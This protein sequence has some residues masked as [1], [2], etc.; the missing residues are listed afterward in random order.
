MPAGAPGYAPRVT[1]TG[2]VAQAGVLDL[3]AAARLHLSSDAAVE[4]LGGTPDQAPDRYR[5]ADPIAALPPPVPVLCVHARD[6]D[7]VPLAQSTAYVAAATGAG[8]RA[9]LCEVPGDHFTVIDPADP[10]WTL[11]RDALPD[12]LAGRLP[13]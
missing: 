10:S 1:V 2:V 8:G 3:A 9:V 13:T 6:D 11:V 12:L 7:I 4:L 5:V